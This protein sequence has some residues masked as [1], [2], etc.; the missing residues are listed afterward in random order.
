MET[1]LHLPCQTSS[2]GFGA[3]PKSHIKKPKPFAVVADNIF[4][5]SKSLAYRGLWCHVMA[6]SFLLEK[7]PVPGAREESQQPRV[8]LE[9]EVP[10]INRKIIMHLLFPGEW[11]FQPADG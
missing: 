4:P 3:D 2:G 5:A 1:Q 8:L 6:C 7:S 11:L 9:V 10:L